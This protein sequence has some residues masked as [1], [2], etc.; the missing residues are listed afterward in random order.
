MRMLGI[1]PRLHW[2]LLAALV[3][4]SPLGAIAR[5]K[6]AGPDSRA[7]VLDYFRGVTLVT[8]K[9]S[10]LVDHYLYLDGHSDSN[11]G[12]DKWLKEINELTYLADSQ[13]LI[14]RTM[15]VPVACRPAHV[16]LLRALDNQDGRL[17]DH[18]RLL[19]WTYR[20]R[21]RKLSPQQKRQWEYRPPHLT[22]DQETM[23]SRKSA[24]YAE[25]FEHMIEPI[26]GRF[27]IPDRY[28]CALEFTL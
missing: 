24:L 7:S 27:H 13:V 25:Q 1:F 20:Y 5:T 18:Y 4:G 6:A 19:R 26:R 9:V 17:K 10:S 3:L 23:N 21:S 22:D 16:I 8:A 11:W 14:A 12:T 2:L 28:G 15:R